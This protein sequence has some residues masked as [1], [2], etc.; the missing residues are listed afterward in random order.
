MTPLF[1]LFFLM[2]TLYLFEK[3]VKYYY[4][5]LIINDLEIPVSD[6][7]R[8]ILNELERIFP[9]KRR[10]YLKIRYYQIE[11]TM[12]RYNFESDTIEIYLDKFSNLLEVTDTVIHEYCHHLQN[13]F[14]ISDINDALELYKYK[15]HNHPWEE[16][17]RKIAKSNRMK[18]LKSIVT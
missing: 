12:G 5:T 3:L 6:F 15:Y 13:H 18:I 1:I 11:K 7:I 14:N 16:E 8:S 2:F 10:Y 17:A 4:S 9:C